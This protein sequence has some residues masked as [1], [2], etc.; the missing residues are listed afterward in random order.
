MVSKAITNAA[1]EVAQELR[2]LS[3]RSSSILEAPVVDSRPSVTPVPG[4]PTPFEGTDVHT[5]YTDVL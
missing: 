2:A 3:A 1:A 4:H 5:Y